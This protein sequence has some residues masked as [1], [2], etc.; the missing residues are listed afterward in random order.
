M[1]KTMIASS[2]L[3]L[4]AGAAT[5]A[6]MNSI[7]PDAKPG[8]CYARVMIPAQYEERM[9]EVVVR[10]ASERVEIVPAQYKWETQRV[11]VSDASV[12]L[13]VVPAR[14]RTVTEQIETSPAESKWVA[15][16][17][18]SSVEAS[19]QML[20]SA[21]SSG[22]SVEGAQHGQCFAEY[23]QSPEYETITRQVMVSE[24]SEKISIV[25]ARYEWVEEQQLV[26]ESSRQLIEIPASYETVTERVMVEEAKVVW[27]PGHGEVERI[28]QYSGNVMCL[29]KVPAV[30]KNVEKRILKAAPST[31][32]VEIPAKYETV[33]V[34]KLI[35]PA[36]QVRVE[37]PARYRDISVTNKVSEGRHFWRE[38]LVHD[39]ADGARKTG[40]VICKKEV[41]AKLS[42]IS[43]LIVDTP[44]SVRE[45]EVPARYE[46]KRVRQ[47][48]SSAVET[49]VEIP[50]QTRQVSKRVKVSD[51]RMAWR[52]VLCETNTT[53]GTI[54]RLQRALNSAGYNAG[55]ID[56]QLSTETLNAVDRYQRDNGMASG[57]L[58]LDVL[59]RLG[60]NPG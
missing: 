19:P 34:H 2:V 50:A 14:L 4:C 18:Y 48:V 8:E 39:L 42:T 30:Y 11:M 26:A 12:R 55:T 43:K 52:P 53:Q 56:G 21:A 1:M 49:R 44:A 15:G 40:N 58:T 28:D 41:P 33:R 35:E 47:I 16:S 32:F 60:V 59:Q 10:E 5:A 37:T 20:S 27:K 25:P 6:D 46:N 17:I 9:M 54:E 24:P 29:V 3:A 38:E 57:G 31:K 22:V 36:R 51:L 45:V 7:L 13:E 23:F